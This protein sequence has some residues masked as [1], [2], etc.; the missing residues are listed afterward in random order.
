MR[1][2]LPS[3]ARGSQSRARG[4]EV[5]S[6][7]KGNRVRVT[8]YNV[9]SANK[10]RGSVKYTNKYEHQVDLACGIFPF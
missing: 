7:R 9:T 2:R 8:Q 5:D 3:R 6:H 4:D 1:A 10:E